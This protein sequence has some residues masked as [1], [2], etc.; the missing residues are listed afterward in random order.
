MQR[1]Q[2]KRRKILFR[3]GGDALCGLLNASYNL[4]LRNLSAYI[5]E[6]PVGDA[7][8]VAA[9]IQEFIPVAR[10]LIGIS[11]LKVISFGPRPDDFL[12]CN[13]PIKCLYDMGASIQENSELDLL[14]AFRAHANDPRIPDVVADMAAELGA[15]N[16][17]PGIL[18]KL[19]Q[20][21][22]TLL[23][24]YNQHK[25][26]ARS[27]VFANKCWPAFQTEFQFVPCYVNSRLAERGIPVACETDIY[28]A[29]SEFIL[30]CATLQTPTLLDINNS[31]PQDMF[32]KNKQL[33]KDYKMTD[34]VMNFHCGNT[35]ACSLK[36]G[37]AAMKYQ[38]IMK[39]LLEPDKEPD[40][41]RGTLEGTLQAGAA[42]LF[43]IQ[44]TADGQ[45][46]SY[47]AEGEV[48][49]IDPL[50]FGAIGVFAVPEFGRFYRHVLIEKNYPHHAGIVFCTAGKTLFSVARYLGIKEIDYNQPRGVLYPSENP[51][52]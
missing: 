38:L 41:T 47:I 30:A 2:K 18:G 35:S 21:E 28:G 39:S 25:G 15:G 11:N 19:A 49:D 44:S 32:I 5:P 29:F 20:Y 52:A 3:V 1:L 51:F 10:A 8:A 24:W 48:L 13:A 27:V 46:R 22:L 6:Y 40:I 23:D 34:L 37:T 36:P 4:A 50:S 16:D 33:I 45:L 43:R 12:A 17:Y 14:V 42:T 26:A 9:M 31:V 7:S